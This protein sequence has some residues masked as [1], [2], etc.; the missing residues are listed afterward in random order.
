MQSSTGPELV[1]RRPASN[2]LYG[3]R[4]LWSSL[5]PRADRRDLPRILRPLPRLPCVPSPCAVLCAERVVLR[6]HLHAVASRRPGRR[7][8][9]PTVVSRGGATSQVFV[10]CE[11]A[12]VSGVTVRVCGV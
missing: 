6:L 8:A 11:R 2:A 9:R 5:D 1:S 10:L 7:A 12:C 4:V 3:V